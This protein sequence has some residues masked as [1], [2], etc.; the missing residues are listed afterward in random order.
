M[1]HV[2]VHGRRRFLDA[3]DG[4]AAVA[5]HRQ[6]HRVAQ[7]LRQ[8]AQQR[9]G[10]AHGVELLQADEAELQRQRAEPVAA[11]GLVLRDEAQLA[12]AHQVRMRLR[13]RHAGFA[14]QVLQRHGTAVVGERDE[15]LP[16][17]LDALD[18]ALPV[19]DLAVHGCT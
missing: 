17:H 10:Q 3:H 6:R 9:R 14:R 8:L 12:V 4:G 13:G 19:G 7:P 16:A 2:D 1:A 15:Q 5:P 11:G 18:A